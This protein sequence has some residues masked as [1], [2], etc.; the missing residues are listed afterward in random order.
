MIN[1]LIS[2]EKLST[3]VFRDVYIEK[4]LTINVM[5]KDVDL[6]NGRQNEHMLFELCQ[7]LVLYKN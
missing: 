5:L 3:Y 2:F 1:N 6:E 4:P 7:E